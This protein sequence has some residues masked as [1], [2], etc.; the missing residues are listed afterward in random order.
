VLGL[1]LSMALSFITF[2][3]GHALY[4]D[5]VAPRTWQLFGA[6]ALSDGLT[7]SATFLV[8]RWAVAPGK[9][10]GRIPLAILLCLG[11]SAILS[12]L[13]LYFG[14]LGTAQALSPGAVLNVLF[15]RAPDGQV[16]EYGPY[17][18]I[19]RTTFLPIALYL[20]VLLIFWLIKVALDPA[21]WIVRQATPRATPLSYLAAATGIYVAAFGALGLLLDQ[22]GRAVEAITA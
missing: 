1:S 15:G 6:N 4:P 2:A 18:W 16:R 10:L 13:A 7:L 14:L 3:L 21:A 17:F 20:L 8:V 11:I 9:L 19:M 12:C 22:I 5:I